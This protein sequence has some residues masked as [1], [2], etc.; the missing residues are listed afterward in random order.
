MPVRT[1]NQLE[2]RWRRGQGVQRQ[3]LPHAARPLVVRLPSLMTVR[4]MSGNASP[5]GRSSAP[6]QAAAACT[7]IKQMAAVHTAHAPPWCRP[8]PSAWS[9]TP[10]AAGA[11]GRKGDW[12]T[13]G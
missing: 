5:T 8:L 6:V 2:L 9:R 10:S 3:A 4:Q 12:C 11:I 13:A 1:V 7:L